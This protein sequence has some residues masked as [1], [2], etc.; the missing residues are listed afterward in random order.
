MSDFFSREEL[1]NGLPAHR[2]GAILFAIESRAAY[3]AAQSR[4]AAACYVLPRTAEAREQAFLQALAQGRDL[5]FQPRIQDL[6][7]YAPQWA[8]LAPDNPGVQATIAHLLAQKYTF[9]SQ[10]VPALRQALGLDD[11]AVQ[12]A[13]RRN[14]DQPLQTIFASSLSPKEQLRWRWASLAQRL[15]T[16]P[17]FWTAYALTVTE[18]V[19]ASILALPIALAGVGPIAGVIQLL[20]LGL[21]NILTI[22]S[23][24]EAI[25]RNG[26]IRYGSSFLGRLVDDYLGKTGMFVLSVTLLVM[27]TFSLTAFYIGVASTLTDATGGPAMLWAAVLFLIG[28]YFLRRESLDATI[29]DWLNG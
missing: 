5:P 6:E 7:R 3:L 4:Q 23:N 28:F 24:A 29:L 8:A 18:T 26:K 9:T 15:E 11:E 19:G 14:Y 27:I 12:A 17:P 25:T 1:L 10:R 20:V 13:F 21:V 22:T 2:A 16:L